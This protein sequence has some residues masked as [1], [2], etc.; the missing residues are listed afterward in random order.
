MA[1]NPD[2]ASDL[3]EKS[4]FDDLLRKLIKTKPQPY[5]E[6]IGKPKKAPKA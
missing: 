5:K 1:K 6:L 4:K 2:R 3:I